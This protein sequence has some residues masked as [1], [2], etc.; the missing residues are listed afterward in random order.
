VAVAASGGPDSTALLHATAR[1]AAGLGI[2]VLGL[3]VHHGLMPEADAWHDHVAAMCRWLAI[4]FDSR[5]LAGQ[6]RRGDSVE[7]WARKGRREA[8]SEM[9]AAHGVTL[10]LLAQHR[11]DQAE[12]WLLQALRGGG[13]A[14]LSA[15]PRRAERD[16]VTWARPWLDQPRAAIEAYLARHR[17]PTVT[18]SSNADPAFARARLRTAV[19]PALTGA[20][21]DAEIALARSA[22]R[23]QEAA[24]VL[25]DVAAADLGAATDGADLVMARWKALPAARRANALRSW[26]GQRLASGVPES[27][28]QRLLVE[29]L[30]SR[31]ATWPAGECTLALRRG[32]LRIASAR[33]GAE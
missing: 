5:R 28:V 16:G 21:P 26:L 14:G 8:L 19:W 12:T 22:A 13:P 7:A 10:L 33:D 3:H 31:A 32:R 27:L 24:A 20:F 25:A 9:A 23:A 6:P 18:D 2:E 17:L 29:L 1:A 15:M 4:G 30:P 11:R